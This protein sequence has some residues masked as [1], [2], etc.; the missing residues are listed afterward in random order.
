MGDETA[1]VDPWPMLRAALEDRLNIDLP[2]A[3][4]AALDLPAADIAAAL[5]RAGE[6]RVGGPRPASV[7]EVDASARRV[8]AGAQWKVTLR[9]ALGGA[10]GLVTLGPEALASLVMSVARW[11]P[12]SRWSCRGGRRPACA[13]RTSSSRRP[14][15]RGG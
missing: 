10:G 4:R 5:D 15:R 12:P 6:A 1:W 11:P 14:A 2:A 3:L 13:C 7:E 9:A 8:V